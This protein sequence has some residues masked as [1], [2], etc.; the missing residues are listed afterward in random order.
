MPEIITKY[1]EIVL[2]I[3]RE[4]GA[5]CGVATQ[6]ILTSCPVER[7]CSLPTG[8]LCIYGLN[9]IPKMTQIS[10]AE[11]IQKVAA[12]PIQPSILS[13]KIILLLIITFIIGVTIGILYKKLIKRKIT[14]NQ[15]L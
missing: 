10:V 4:S 13:L 12:Q 3:L 15:K 8:E 9:E 7:F 11:I 14:N 1:P 6:K 5:E 2:Q